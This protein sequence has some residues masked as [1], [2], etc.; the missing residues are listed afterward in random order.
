MVISLC[1]R[2]VDEI[3]GAKSCQASSEES[4]YLAHIIDEA[5]LVAITAQSSLELAGV[6]SLVTH[7]QHRR[8]PSQCRANAKGR[9]HLDEVLH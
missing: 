6:Q 4:M 1:M 3:S 9:V 7:D 5:F 8:D 2:N